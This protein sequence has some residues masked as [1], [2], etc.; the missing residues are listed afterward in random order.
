MKEIRKRLIDKLAY[1]W[2]TVDNMKSRL[3]YLAGVL[4]FPEALSQLHEYTNVPAID[5]IRILQEAYAEICKIGVEDSDALVEHIILSEYLDI[6]YNQNWEYLQIVKKTAK[7]LGKSFITESMSPMN[8]TKFVYGLL[9]DVYSSCRLEE[10]FIPLDD[11]TPESVYYDNPLGVEISYVGLREN[12]FV[13]DI[14]YDGSW[15]QIQLP[16]HVTDRSVADVIT[17]LYLVH[18]FMKEDE[19]GQA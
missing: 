19:N 7:Q 8:E 4:N 5:M 2:K 14:R 6:L 16:E 1:Q 13:Y 10:P 11:S 17:L 15:I 18:V 12:S 3:N 9:S